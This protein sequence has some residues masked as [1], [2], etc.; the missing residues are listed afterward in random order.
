MLAELSANGV[1]KHRS[2][3]LEQTAAEA[4]LQSLFNSLPG[5]PWSPS[6]PKRYTAQPDCD[7]IDM[8]I[9]ANVSFKREMTD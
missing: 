8:S 2:K 4:E 6:S 3:S 5:P 9:I 7:V 1:S